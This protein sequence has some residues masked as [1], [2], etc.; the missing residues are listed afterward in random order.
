MKERTNSS[1]R[2]F[3]KPFPF[4]L[5]LALGVVWTTPATAREKG[6]YMP[7]ANAARSDIPD[8]YHW[9][10][11]DLW[12]TPEAWE[13]A[14]DAVEAELPEL[15]DFKGKLGD[16]AATLR[17]AFDKWYSMTQTLER[18]WVYAS[19]VFSS[20]RQ[21]SEAKGRLDRIKLMG[22][23]L[24]SAAAFIEPELLK[25]SK[26][27]I[28]KFLAKEDG[29]QVYAHKL[30]DLTRRKEHV[31]TDQAEAVLALSGDLR[32]GPYSMLNALQQDL[33]FPKVHDEDGKEI[34]LAFANF[35]RFRASKK[36]E[37][38]KEAVEKFF[39]TLAEKQR[40]FAAS[41]DMGVK[42]DIFVARARKYDS[43]LEASLD[44]DSVPVDVFELLL[45]SMADNLPR[46][47]H[48]YVELRKKALGLD[49]LH[50]YDLYAPMF[51]SAQRSMTY[52][53][54]VDVIATALKPLGD[55]YLDVLTKGMQVGS[56]W[57]DV[58]PNKGKRSG[59]YQTGA[60]RVHPFVFLNHMNELDDTFTAA[61]EYGHAMHSY[62]SDHNQDFPN[63]AYPIFLAEIASTFNEELLLN[64]LLAN[65]KSKEE[66][67][68]LLAKRLENIRQTVFRQIM[69]AEF[70][71]DIHAE[72]ENGGALTADRISEIYGALIQKYYGPGFSV[73]DRDSIE[74]SYV[75]HFYYNFYVYK[76][77]TGLMSAIALSRGVLAGEE[78]ALD[79]YLTML[80]SG[81]SDYPIPILK[82]AGVDLHKA[83]AMTATYD[84]FEET[85]A[86]L[87]ALL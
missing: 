84:L 24:D 35:P 77:A 83:D 28:E 16:S 46:T 56:G 71:R 52:E 78:G 63:A 59:A 68:A 34:E 80:K 19:M 45:K 21:I 74:W 75:P 36:R 62:L 76:Y 26:E 66:K 50:Y 55:D 14:R 22:T 60:Y 47:L 51:P 85:I 10:L 30:D 58:F 38:R 20:D 6:P 44:D 5:A 87:E 31:L 9:N 69:F 15:E 2:R 82:R 81:G 11:T 18:L 23:K 86:Q 13:K 67:K 64:H 79:R 7:D 73:D 43:A 39:A 40:S 29:L 65:A 57:A 70:E 3:W 4:V 54:S 1:W 41:L 72:V 25:M 37:V 17:S 42:R 32:G 8:Q 49:D 12:K 48:R 27:D 61:H 53:E 33:V